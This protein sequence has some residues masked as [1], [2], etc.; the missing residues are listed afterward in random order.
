MKACHSSCWT[1]KGRRL[2]RFVVATASVCLFL[3]SSSSSPSIHHEHNAHD[4]PIISNDIITKVNDENRKQQIRTRRR[5]QVVA[6]QVPLFLSLYY[7]NEGVARQLERANPN[8]SLVSHVCQAV[9]TQVRHACVCHFENAY[10]V[11]G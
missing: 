5:V 1:M 8:N 4:D 6:R 3:L 9:N 11:L 7:V 2:G 10:F